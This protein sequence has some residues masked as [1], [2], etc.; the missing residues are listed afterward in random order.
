MTQLPGVAGEIEET[1][2]LE[3]TVT[4]LKARGGTVVKIPN[5]PSGTLLARIVG[6]QAT[7][8][9]INRI[10]PG[11]IDLPCGHMRGRDATR[12]EKKRRAFDML[13]EG[14]SLREV[15]LACDIHLRTASQY[16]AEMNDRGP[17][18]QSEFP[19]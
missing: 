17:S 1:I 4:L 7:A 19:F 12:L 6:E 3:L 15:A 13:A 14:K 10:G 2:G 5:K 16:R 9:L 18:Q 11:N 8:K